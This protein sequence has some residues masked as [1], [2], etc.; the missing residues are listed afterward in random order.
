MSEEVLRVSHLTTRLQIGKQ[1]HKVV[2]DLSFSLY[3]GRTLAIVGESGCGK[4]LTALSLMRI[5]PDPPALPAEGQ[6]LFAG[7]NLLEISEREMR[8]IRGRHLSMI[9]QD[10]S[11]ALNPVYSIGVQLA[12]MAGLHLNLYGDEAE[13]KCTQALSDVG[14]PSARE[15]L[16]NYPHQLS[17]GMRQRVMIAMALM[18]EPKILIADE[19]TTA[20]DVTVQ[21][22][23]LELLRHLQSER[24]MA[25]LLITHDLGV[26][27]EMADDVLLMYA[28]C[29]V[30]Q[31]TVREIFHQPAHP[32]TQ[33]LFASR[34][35]LESVKGALKPIKGSV[36]PLG[37][38]PEGCHFHPRCPH[39]MPSCFQG[40]VPDFICGEQGHKARCWLCSEKEKPV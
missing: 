3:A 28:S 27:A 40:A 34:P 31:G 16:Q 17:G 18:C 1:A 37:S 26:V 5:L 38:F 14:I 4:S 22:Q 7:R 33:G 25:L 12:E 36:P 20:L 39:T 21:A 11:T 15:R 8:R 35:N 19:P 6:V 32:Y 24:G 9:F 30:E 13:A 29:N 2:D 10:A 23:I